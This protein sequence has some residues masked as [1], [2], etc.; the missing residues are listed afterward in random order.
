MFSVGSAGGGSDGTGRVS[1][2][3]TGT[4]GFVITGLEAATLAALLDFVLSFCAFFAA[5]LADEGSAD[6][7]PLSLRL[8]ASSRATACGAAAML[9]EAC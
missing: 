1:A 6:P 3:C 2:D 4:L 9:C 8:M 7:S 5:Q